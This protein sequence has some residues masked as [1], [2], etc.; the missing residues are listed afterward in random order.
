MPN[1]TEPKLGAFWSAGQAASA[2]RAPG[3]PSRPGRTASVLRR[4]ELAP[5]SGMVQEPRS[6]CGVTAHSGAHYLGLWPDRKGCLWF[7]LPGCHLFRERDE[8]FIRSGRRVAHRS[9]MEFRS[10]G[11]AARLR[12]VAQHLHWAVALMSGLL[13]SSLNCFVSVNE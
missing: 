6:T 9:W 1:R 13:F 12:E 7:L 3:R 5:G 10:L 8:V 11:T 4:K 2:N